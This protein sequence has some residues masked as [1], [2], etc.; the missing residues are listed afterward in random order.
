M[1]TVIYIFIDD[2]FAGGSE[3]VVGRASRDSVD[4]KGENFAA[5]LVG[6][7]RGG[8]GSGGSRDDSAA[9][10]AVGV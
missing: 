6:S 4:V 9:I 10:G 7:A 2:K 5:G 1:T 3:L 8:E